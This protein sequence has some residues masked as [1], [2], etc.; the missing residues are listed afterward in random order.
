MGSAASRMEEAE[1]EE[2]SCPYEEIQAKCA[3][4]APCAKAK[5]LLEACAA[6]IEEKGSG[7]CEA[8]AFDFWHC[9]D[10]CAVPAVRW[11]KREND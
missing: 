8:W 6:R 3:D 10:Q 11:R 1:P 4:T 9:I 5:A 7:E 2:P